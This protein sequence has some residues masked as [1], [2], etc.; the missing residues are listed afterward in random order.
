MREQARAKADVFMDQFDEDGRYEK[1]DGELSRRCEFS[2]RE[3]VVRRRERNHETN[4]RD[5]RAVG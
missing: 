2:N 4:R 5:L 3:H 1:G